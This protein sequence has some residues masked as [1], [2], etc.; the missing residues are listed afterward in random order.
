MAQ[1]EICEDGKYSCPPVCPFVP[2]GSMAEQANAMLFDDEEP[3]YD[4]DW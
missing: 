2:P 3:V 4:G 1:C